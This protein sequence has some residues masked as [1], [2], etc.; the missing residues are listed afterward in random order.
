[1]SRLV[2]G[3]GRVEIVDLGALPRSAMCGGH[4]V[5]EYAAEWADDCSAVSI[6]AIKD[7]CSR[8]GG[9]LRTGDEPIELRLVSACHAP[10]DSCAE[11]AASPAGRMYTIAYPDGSAGV[12]T[13]GVASI[14][15]VGE[16]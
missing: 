11:M 1:M 6:K 15:E 3:H 5:G 16:Q 4:A 10:G 2:S 9:T 12:L 14:V 13:G 7:L 8:R